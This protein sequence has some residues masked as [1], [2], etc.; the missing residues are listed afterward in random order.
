M[1]ASGCRLREQ[2]GL[3][4]RLTAVTPRLELGLRAPWPEPLL[5]LWAFGL[6]QAWACIFA[7]ALLTLVVATAL[8]PPAQMHRYDL[9]FIGA[10]V[11][12][13][14]LLGSG[15]ERPA[16]AKAILV[17]HLV[18]TAMELF[19][20]SPAIGSW[21]YPGV[22][23]AIFT[24]GG[25][26]LFAGFMYSAVGSYLARVWRLFDLRF[27]GFGSLRSAGIL[28]AIAYLNFFSHHFLPDLRWALLAVIAWKLR[29]CDVLF[30]VRNADRRMP[31]LLGLSLVA[32]FIWIAENLAT[33]ARVWVYPAQQAGWHVVSPHKILA[34]F[35][36]MFL[37]FVLVAALHPGS[38]A[39]PSR[40]RAPSSI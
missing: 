11:L 16:E 17:F 35:L 6:K 2:V 5:E 4:V 31:M 28:A 38:L 3:F 25:V 1:G 19:K 34:W 40:R 29:H 15:L 36:L 13:V 26:P 33:L 23:G 9:L 22:E 30:R 27:P 14:L 12:Q 32:A 39:S 20:T 21:T 37:S 7:G 24:V 10:L 18:A 8:W